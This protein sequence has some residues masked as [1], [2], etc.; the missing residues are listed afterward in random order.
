M[1]LLSN[2]YS[3]NAPAPPYCLMKNLLSYTVIPA[4]SPVPSLK[5]WLSVRVWKLSSNSRS[6]NS[7]S[8]P[9]S[10]RCPER[11]NS[12]TSTIQVLLLNW[13]LTIRH[14]FTYYSPTFIQNTLRRAVLALHLVIQKADKKDTFNDYLLKKSHVLVHITEFKALSRL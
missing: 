7:T 12:Y 13:I 6:C 9:V 8:L 3:Q 11:D 14:L 2:V 5:C 10:V 4:L 1:K